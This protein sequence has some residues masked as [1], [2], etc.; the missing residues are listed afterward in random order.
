LSRTKG[1]QIRVARTY[2]E[3]LAKGS[4][5][6]ADFL[7]SLDLLFSRDDS[8]DSPK[9]RKEGREWR[10][11]PSPEE[12]ADEISDNHENDVPLLN[13]INNVPGKTGHWMFA[14]NSR[15]LGGRNMEMVWKFRRGISPALA[16]TVFD[17]RRTLE[18]LLEG[19]E[20]T[21]MAVFS[22]RPEQFDAKV[23][24]TFRER[25]AL[26]NIEV[27]DTILPIDFS[28]GFTPGTGETVRDLEKMG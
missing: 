12:I 14:R 25:L 7:E 9:G 17:G 11:V 22:D 16:L 6:T 27:D 13:L 2:A 18:F 4:D 10:R 24:R 26:M 5:P 20:H 8:D 3:L 19:L 23:W 28:D 21:R 15:R 1:I